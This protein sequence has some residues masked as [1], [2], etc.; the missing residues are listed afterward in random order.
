MKVERAPVWLS[1]AIA[2]RDPLHLT[3]SSSVL[4]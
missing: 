2:T 4:C 1:R 3:A